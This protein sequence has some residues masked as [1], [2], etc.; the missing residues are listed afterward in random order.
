[1]TTPPILTLRTP[2]YRGIEFRP[3]GEADAEPCTPSTPPAWRR[4]AWISS[5][6]RK[7]AQP[8]GHAPLAG[9]GHRGG[10]KGAVAA[11]PGR[12]AGW[13]TASWKAG[14]RKIGVWVYFIRGAVLPAWRRRGIGSAL[15]QWAE[16]KAHAQAAAE[17]L[18]ERFEFAANASSTELD[19]A[20]FL[21]KQ[22][23]YIGFTT[24]EMG[25]DPAT[26]LPPPSAAARRHRAASRP[27]RAYPADHR[28]RHRVLPQLVPRQP[29]PHHLRP[30]SLFH[31]QFAKPNT[32]ATCGTSPGM[33]T[34]SP[35]RC[36]SSRKAG[37]CTSP[38]SACGSV[39]AEGPGAG[40]AGARP[41][42]L[43]GP[44]RHR[45]LDR[46]LRRIL[47]PGGRPVHRAG[48][49]AAEGVWA[50]PQGCDLNGSQL[51]ARQHQFPPL[52][53]THHPPP[54]YA[55][56]DEEGRAEPRRTGRAAFSGQF[57]YEKDLQNFLAKNL[58]LIEKGLR[59][60]EDEGIQGIEFPVGGQV[61]R[62]P[63]A[64]QLQ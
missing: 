22:G 3:R 28:Q 14:T 36:S 54:V 41:P 57:A 25:F 13:A 38:R 39:A 34:R 53:P 1:M 32:T 55:G 29:L 48:L 46:H 35:G 42:R 17:H 21:R 4:M 43:P 40:V 49:Q 37:R 16:A 58:H 23:Y 26:L 44:R 15:M 10:G 7:N 11:R 60:Y 31:R 24:L 51:P 50:V 5:C 52:Q 62:Y 20:A 61:H 56:K 27:A 64:G 59:L 47:Q 2:Q 18:G 63:C 33:A 9:A 6:T 8:G 12:R 30:E 45:H 19:T